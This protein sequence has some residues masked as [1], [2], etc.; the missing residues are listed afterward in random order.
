ML[1]ELLLYSLH[2]APLL[3]Y[4]LFLERLPFDPCCVLS[5]LV[6]SNSNLAENK[7]MK[8][9]IKFLGFIL[10]SLSLRAEE[11]SQGYQEQL[12]AAIMQSNS[13]KVTRLLK[14]RNRASIKNF[15]HMLGCAHDII[16]ERRMLEITRQEASIISWSSLIGTVGFI[17]G[18]C[19]YFDVGTFRTDVKGSIIGEE[20]GFFALLGLSSL[21]MSYGGYIGWSAPR[22]RLAKSYEILFSLEDAIDEMEKKRRVQAMIAQKRSLASKRII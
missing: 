5:Y 15:N 3:W 9:I 10:L 1:F 19:Y 2:F 13:A 21:L 22:Y 6:V 16:E 17:A 18:L 8:Y 11:V 14:R 4:E 7:Y 12:E 20:R